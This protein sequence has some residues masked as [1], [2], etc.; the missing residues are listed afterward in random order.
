MQNRHSPIHA[1]IFHIM[2]I[3]K[4]EED[5]CFFHILFS[6]CFYMPKISAGQY[7]SHAPRHSAVFFKCKPTAHPLQKTMRFLLLLEPHSSLYYNIIL[8]CYSYDFYMYV[9]CPLPTTRAFSRCMCNG[10][11]RIIFRYCNDLP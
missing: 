2:N 8:F 6:L 5:A 9:P 4:R 11:G 1:P 7:H 3:V 10:K